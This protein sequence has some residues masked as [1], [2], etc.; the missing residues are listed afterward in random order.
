MKIIKLS[1][2]LEKNL[3]GLEDIILIPTMGNLHEG[4]IS[5]ITEAK[6]ISNNI[7]LSIFI[8]PIQFN[9]KNDLESYPRTLDNDINLLNNTDVSILFNPSEEDIYQKNSKL[10]YKM[11]MI[12]NELCGKSRPGHFKGVL[13]V[14]DRL[15]KLIKPSY[16]IFGKKDYQQLYLIKKF[17]LESNL[18]IKII[19]APTIRS[20]NNLALSSRNNL[21]STKD[22][23]NAIGLYK[24]LQICASSVISGEKIYDAE[25][26]AKENLLKGGWEI[27]Y[28]EI[29]RQADLKKPTCNDLKLVALGAGYFSKIRL[30]DNIEFCIPATN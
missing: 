3:K 27:D 7:I 23:S 14:I 10:S 26:N 30:I 13:T 20:T 2:E 25:L 19:E 18:S 1:L 6:K 4:H 9:S 28:F 22:I 8:N 17:V 24:Q 15:F 16:A 12:S 29:R 11:P 21:L 5:L